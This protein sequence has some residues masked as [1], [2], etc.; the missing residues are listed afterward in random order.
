VV[1]VPTME[2][3]HV[4]NRAVINYRN[5]LYCRAVL[6]YID[7]LY[8]R[9]GMMLVFMNHKWLMIHVMVVL[10]GDETCLKIYHS[11]VFPFV[12]EREPL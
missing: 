12:F 7:V 8:Y 4:L 10:E 3:R 2:D 6:Y 5:G 1:I 11:C 9:S